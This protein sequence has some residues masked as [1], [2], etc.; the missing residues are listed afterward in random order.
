[1]EIAELQRAV[2]GWVT[3]NQT[4]AGVIALAVVVVLIIAVAA[5]WRRGQRAEIDGKLTPPE[6][7]KVSYWMPPQRY[8]IARIESTTTLSNGGVFCAVFLALHNILMILVYLGGARSAVQEA[9]IGTVWIAGN[10]LWGV[11]MMM[12]RRQTYIVTRE[13]PQNSADPPLA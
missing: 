3:S 4:A 8:E 5:A 2:V 9:S 11:C 10:I 7:T 13:S 1:M 12:G 6:P